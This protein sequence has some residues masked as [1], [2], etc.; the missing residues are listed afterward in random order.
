MIEVPN[1]EGIIP[2]PDIF[3][4]KT[5]SVTEEERFQPKIVAREDLQ[6][7]PEDEIY[8]P[9]LDYDGLRLLLG[10]A[11][12]FKLKLFLCDISTAFLCGRFQ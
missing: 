4:I 3:L 5:D 8:T 1:K 9:V 11:A 12:S 6:N 10:I 7:T 2:V